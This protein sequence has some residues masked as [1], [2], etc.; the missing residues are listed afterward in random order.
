MAQKGEPSYADLVYEAFRSAGRPLTFQEIFD[1]V[2]RRRRVT[3]RDPRATIRHALTQ[4]RQLLSLGDGRYGYL[5]HLVQ[6]SLLRLPLVEKEPADHPLIYS[7][8][9]R[10]ALW[11]SFLEI[12]KRRV[13]RPVQ[14][15]LPNGDDVALSPDFFGNGVWGSSMPEGLRRYLVENQA[16]VG[17]SLLIRVVDTEAGRGEAWLEPRRKRDEAAMAQR[18]R[19]L[20]DVAHQV[21]LKNPWHQLFIWDLAAAALGR[22]LY[23]SAVAPD[24]LETVLN[25]DP[26]FVDSGI[27]TWMPAEAVTPEVQAAIRHRKETEAELF[28]PE[29]EAV[30]GPEEDLSPH[31]LRRATERTMADVG[32]LLSD[33]EFGSIEEANAFLQDMLTRGGVPR[34]QAGTPLERAQDLMFDAWESPAPR[35]RV[36]LALKALQ[37]SPDCADAYVLLAE[38]TARNPR[39]AADLYSRGVAAGERALGKGA[40]EENIGHF[41]GIVETRPYMRARL[42]L[43]QALWPMG[44]RQE[45]IAHAWDML[46][47]NP[48]DNQGV[49]Y[50]LLNWLLEG[51]D[52]AQLEKLLDLYPDD[53]AAVWLYGRALHAFRTEGDT[54]HARELRAEAEQ[55]NPHVPAYL[56]GRK[57]LPRRLP[58]Y[59][60]WGD[61]SEAIYCAAEQMAA[62]RKSPG[63]R[64]W[65]G[66]RAG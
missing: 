40:F 38:E 44:K 55:Q 61:E 48:G 22:G 2:N 58:Q 11:P 65:L 20:A 12:Q 53:A 36:R 32:A 21:L 47:L 14:V 57:Q 62:W 59:V 9:I 23:R 5:P 17:D 30:A 64:E 31:A 52:D 37:V 4:G 3:T 24:P 49:R 60:G 45:A 8:E 33:R 39:E 19:E 46:R 10:H 16:A 18:N 25:A 54:P 7:D 35:E 26:R 34:R 27:Q 28:R 6:G 1:E 42:G 51:G 13:I 15:R 41:W 29:D 63:A 43:S 66:E 56:L 50:I